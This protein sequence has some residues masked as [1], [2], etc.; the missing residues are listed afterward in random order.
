[1]LNS[2]FIIVHATESSSSYLWRESD[3][4]RLT[5]VAVCVIS[6]GVCSGKRRHIGGVGADAEGFQ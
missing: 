6:R 2:S 4:F 3:Q 1:M 5:G